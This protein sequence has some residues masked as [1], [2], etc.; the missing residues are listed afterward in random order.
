MSSTKP[1]IRRRRIATAF[2]SASVALSIAA[3]GG[4]DSASGTDEG[5]Y[6]IG[7]LGSLSGP[8]A[9][10]GTAMLGGVNLAIDDTNA[11]GGVNGRQIKLVTEDD[12]TDASAGITAARAL[13]SQDVLMV[14]GGNISSVVEGVLPT[15]EREKVPF[16]AQAASPAILDPVKET[17]FQI[18]QTSSS[19]A[20]PMVEFSEEL[21]G[22]DDFT[23]GIGP[24]ESPAGRAWGDNVEKLES[25]GDF[26]ISSRVTLP[27]SPGDIT[28]QAQRLVAGSPDILLLQ[29]PDGV[30]VPLAR[31]I[32]DL[33][34]D[35]PIANFSYGSATKTLETIADKDLYVLRT[36]AQYDTQSKD[37]GTKKF[38]KLVDAAGD[39]E[40]AKSATQYS[41]GYLLGLMVVQA[42]K[43]CGENCDRA[44]VTKTLN[45]IEVDTGGFTPNPM[46]FSPE[47]HLAT[48]SGVFYSFDGKRIVQALDGKAFAATVYSL[49]AE[50]PTS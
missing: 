8:L 43:N 3:C 34:Y 27:V 46:S 29:A 23:A 17:M 25:D 9:P 6:Q 39:Q 48:K 22:T 7:F 31:K 36:A 11:N 41:Q 28:A 16:L 38:V 35:G 33:G 10:V 19:N 18:D 15:L 24:V 12:E 44:A 49:K 50:V 20:Q 37:P 30:L 13:V 32:R 14:T 4:S 45:D 26:T 21:L 2:L 1:K 5:S 40:V 42:L 47:D